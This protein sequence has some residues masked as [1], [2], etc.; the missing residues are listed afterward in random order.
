[1]KTIPKT[2]CRRSGGTANIAAKRGVAGP[3]LRHTVK[4][5]RENSAI[6]MARTAISGARKG[7]RHSRGGCETPPC[8]GKRRLPE[9]R[10]AANS[11]RPVLLRLSRRA[12]RVRQHQLIADRRIL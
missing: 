10:Q 11:L 4:Q 1:M 6:K 7:P 12:S 3:M 8:G 2:F 5:L 9:K